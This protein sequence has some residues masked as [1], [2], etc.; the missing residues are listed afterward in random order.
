TGF[1]TTDYDRDGRIDLIA[2][3]NDFS[4][5]GSIGRFDGGLGHVLRNDPDAVGG[6]TPVPAEESGLVVPGAARAVRSLL[7]GEEMAPLLLVTRNNDSLLAFEE[8]AR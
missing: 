5:I 8:G 2:V 4:P 1:A 6:F 3:Q 7:R